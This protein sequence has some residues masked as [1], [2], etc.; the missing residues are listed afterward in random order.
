LQEWARTQGNQQLLLTAHSRLTT[1]LSLL[2]QQRES[3][4]LLR[5]LL[6]TLDNSNIA[7][8]AVMLDLFQRRQQIYAPDTEAVSDEWAPYTPP[9][10]PVPAASTDIL[11]SLP[12]IHATLPLFFYGWILRIQGQLPEAVACLETV[13]DLAKSTGQPAIAGMAYHQLAIAAR[14]QGDMVASHTLND[15]SLRIH[16]EMQGAAAELT[17]MWPRIS[18]AFIA[19]QR[20][21]VDEA[22]RRLRRVADFLGDQDLYRSYRNSAQIGLGLVTLV[23]GDL[24]LAQNQL[25]TALADPVNLYP[26]I[27]VQALLGLATI[28]H[29][30]GDT[31]VC[32]QTLQRALAYAGQRSLLEEYMETV[33]LIA[34]L[35]P[36]DAP[37]HSLLAALLGYV[38]A[39]SAQ[40]FIHRLR[41]ALTSEE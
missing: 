31:V 29:R 6:D 1:M 34:N 24:R 4:E 10:P 37:V 17:S 15:Q 11:Q 25:H 38:E 3:N 18:S 9:P 19:L 20:N 23:R 7:R 35:Q 12:P 22:E 8:S 36:V 5:D 41:A 13:V 26:Y 30:Q 21:Q 40:P 39:L 27:Y 14:M 2:G 16:G 33:L 28:A 32:R